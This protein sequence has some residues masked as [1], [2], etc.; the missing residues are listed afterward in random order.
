MTS[1]KFNLAQSSELSALFKNFLIKA[2]DRLDSE[3]ARSATLGL[4]RIKLIEALFYM[5]KFDLFSLK[6]EIPETKFFERLFGLMKTYHMN[7]ILHNEVVKILAFVLET[8]EGA[9]L[10][11]NVRLLLFSCLTKASSSISCTNRL[12]L[13]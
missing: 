8:D 9:S 11:P 10:I 6:T 13:T 5:L 7:N 4:G 2:V 12:R 1:L 3:R